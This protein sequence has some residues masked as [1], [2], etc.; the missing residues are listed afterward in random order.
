LVEHLIK[1][2]I[3]GSA[4]RTKPSQQTVVDLIS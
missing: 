2:G 4:S 1:Y 3:E